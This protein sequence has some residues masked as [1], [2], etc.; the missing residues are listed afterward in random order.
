MKHI[1]L[2]L[3]S[4]CYLGTYAFTG[5]E[6]PS[7]SSKTDTTIVK[8][9]RK[10]KFEL[11]YSSNNTYKGRKDTSNSQIISPSFKYTSKSNFYIRTA[12]ANSSGSKK[13]FDELD[14]TLG[15]KFHFTKNWDGI[16]S[17]SHYF[18]DSNVSRIGAAV[19][20]D[21][22][23]STGYD[24]DILYSQLQFDWS[25]G[26]SKFKYKGKRLDK[27]THDVTFILANSHQFWLDD[28][29]KDGDDLVIEPEIDILYGTQNFLTTYKGKRDLANKAFQK[30]ASTYAITGYIMTLNV[31]YDIKNFTFGLSPYYT[32]PT[33]VPPGEST[34]P[35]FV[36]YANIYYTIKGKK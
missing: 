22:V 8:K 34:S 2:L 20:N 6:L 30:K 17:E 4:C 21:I 36:M 13:V 26:N 5:F 10:Y 28:V 33:N 9:Y 27:R 14:A 12:L 25:S 19:Q 24:W 23:A 32:I 11:S 31:D 35:Y 1:L 18:F 7:D 29:L 16:L 15:K 3:F